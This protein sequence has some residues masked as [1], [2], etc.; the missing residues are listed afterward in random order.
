MLFP[1]SVFFSEHARAVAAFAESEFEGV[2]QAAALVGASDDT[3]D[4]DVELLGF[5]S[6]QQASGFFERGDGAVDAHAGETTAAE[7]GGG[8]EEDGRAI[9]GYRGHDHQAGAGGDAFEGKQVIIKRATP[10]GVAVLEAAAVAGDDPER[11]GVVR[12]FGWQVCNVFDTMLAARSLG[13]PELGLAA[14]LTKRHNIPV[15]KRFQR[16]DWR[17]RPLTA[18]QLAYAQLDTHFLLAL[19]ADLQA[20]LARQALLPEASE[21]FER[22]LRSTARAAQRAP[23]N[24]APRGSFWQVT[25]AR[26]LAPRAAAILQAVHAY[27]EDAARKADQPPFKIMS[28][29]VLLALAQQAPRNPGQ[30][31]SVGLAGSQQQQHGRQLL[32]AIER[33]RAAKPPVL[34]V[35][36]RT[37]P[38]VLVRYDALHNWRKARAKT[39]G[40]ESDVIV[41]REALWEIAVN[42]PVADADLEAVTEMGPWRRA[43]YASELLGVVQRANAAPP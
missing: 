39:R 29:Q 3:I 15:N 20:E 22:L 11:A 27:R 1:P 30:L 40:V 13:W 33:G 9:L 34:P 43:A 31:R 23:Q 28:D 19:R 35:P 24:G 7:I 17:V 5:A 21:E 12:D 16:A 42:N 2:G 10:D 8:F 41:A 36:E 14:L 26:L 32:E 25:G 37:D 4:H 18:E 38:R 6:S